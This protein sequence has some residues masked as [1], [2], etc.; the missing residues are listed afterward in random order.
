MKM[1]RLRLLPSRGNEAV[2]Q[3][4]ARHSFYFAPVD[5]LSQSVSA[6]PAMPPLK[7]RPRSDRQTEEDGRRSRN[8]NARQTNTYPLRLRTQNHCPEGARWHRSQRQSCR[9]HWRIRRHRPGDDTVAEAGATVVVPVLPD[10]ARQ[11]LSG[12]ARVEQDRM[13]LLDPNSIDSFA[14][15]FFPADD[16]CTCSLT[17]PASW[18]RR[19]TRRSRI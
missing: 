17:T 6:K 11:A 8:H 15:S 3:I 13:D 10:E 2:A 19:W 9:C 18:R 7:Q 12:I 14:M 5:Y 1:N 4:G 16:R